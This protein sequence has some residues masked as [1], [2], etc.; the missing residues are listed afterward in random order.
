M[1]KGKP[2]RHD[3]ARHAP[4]QPRNLADIFP[5]FIKGNSVHPA[6]DICG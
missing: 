6:Q 1:L 3:D 5:D 2:S 4:T